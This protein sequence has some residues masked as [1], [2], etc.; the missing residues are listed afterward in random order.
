MSETMYLWMGILIMFLTTY[1]VR[2]VPMLLFRKPI[3]SRFIKSFLYYVPYSVL[4][5]MT[6][7]A[8]LTCTSSLISALAGTAVALVMA[9]KRASLVKVALMAAA[10]VLVLYML[11]I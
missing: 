3:H 10:V 9:W 1:L 7:P 8:I 11:G 5:A 4:S 2:V 6:F